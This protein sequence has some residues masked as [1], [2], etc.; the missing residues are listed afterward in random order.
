MKM[1]FYWI[2]IFTLILTASMFFFRESPAL[3]GGCAPS[4]Q[5]GSI[6]VDATWCA[7][8]SPYDVTADI[9]VEEGVLLIIEPGVTVLIKT[10]VQGDGRIRINGTLQA[11]GTDANPIVFDS[12]WADP[13]PRDWE[14]IEFTSTSVNSTLAYA[15]LT[16]AG[17][18]GSVG[19]IEIRTSSVVIQNNTLTNNYEHGIRVTAGQPTITHNNI[20]GNGT[21]NGN[22]YGI[23]NNTGVRVEAP[24]NYWGDFSG[25]EH[26]QGNPYG[27]GEAVSDDVTFTPWLVSPAPDGACTGVPNQVYLP[28]LVR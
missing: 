24:C 10:P 16:N 22:W 6:A 20:M 17:A 3:A 13:A 14:Y 26:A 9:T 25:P 21:H 12:G 15:T 8:N 19:A 18:G 4:S 27:I 11:I 2:T 5:S 7:A 23:H 1:K 28:F